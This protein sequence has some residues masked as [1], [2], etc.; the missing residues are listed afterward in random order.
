MKAPPWEHRLTPSTWLKKVPG[1]PDT[2][3]R[4]TVIGIAN[5]AQIM[6]MEYA[7]RSVAVALND[8]E[9]HRTAELRG[10]GHAFHASCLRDMSDVVR[11]ASATRRSRGCLLYT[12]PSPRDRG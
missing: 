8:A 5:T 2:S 12:S 6:V 4:P 1:M 10:C 3:I 7:Y 11:I 9:G